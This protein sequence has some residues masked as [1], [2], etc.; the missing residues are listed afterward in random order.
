MLYTG[1]GKRYLRET[2]QSREEFAHGG[3]KQV[4][5]TEGPLTAMSYAA[6]RAAFYGDSP[7]L[8]VVDTHKLSTEIRWSGEYEARA[9]NMG[10]FLPYDLSVDE[11]GKFGREAPLA[12]DVVA[13]QVIRSSAEEVSEEVARYLAGPP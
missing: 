6:Q 8:L 12:L 1:T 13:D 11:D 4:H 7:V 2:L 5:L 10:S 3:E 9:L